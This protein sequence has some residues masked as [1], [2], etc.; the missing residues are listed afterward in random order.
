[1]SEQL[2]DDTAGMS[3]TVPEAQ[4]A[5]AA[6]TPGQDAKPGK[7]QYAVIVPPTAESMMQVIP[8]LLIA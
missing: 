7:K 5:A 6:A 1:M 2:G 8:S 4:D 3:E